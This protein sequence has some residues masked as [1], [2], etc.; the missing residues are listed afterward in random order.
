MILQGTSSS[1]VPKHMVY[2]LSAPQY[3]YYFCLLIS[4]KMLDNTYPCLESYLHVGQHSSSA[5]N[6][7]FKL[8]LVKYDYQ[9]IE[10]DIA[11][12]TPSPFYSS[13]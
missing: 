12:I 7:D 13:Y 5:H 2:P 4:A 6:I 1:Q 8:A 9:A 3:F 10:L 11:C